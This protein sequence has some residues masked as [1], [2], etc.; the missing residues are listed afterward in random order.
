MVATVNG[1]EFI[2]TEW[3]PYVIEGLPLGTVTIKL[4]LKDGAGNLV[5]SPFNPVERSVQ[6]E[7]ADV[8]G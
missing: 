3:K 1:V 5:D 4:E 6:L 2:L 8:E 7:A